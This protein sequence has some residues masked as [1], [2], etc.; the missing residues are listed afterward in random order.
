MFELSF[1]L[2]RK[3]KLRSMEPNHRCECQG[4][5]ISGQGEDAYYK[6]SCKEQAKY[7]IGIGETVIIGGE[8][9]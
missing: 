2:L 3:L 1:L 5:Q 4:V 6:E 9:K 8:K 7:N